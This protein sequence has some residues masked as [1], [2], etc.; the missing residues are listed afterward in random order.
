MLTSCLYTMYKV[1]MHVVQCH[2][3][4]S[5]N[6]FLH[7]QFHFVASTYMQVARFILVLTLVLAVD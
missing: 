2:K 3:M 1:T 4:C 5:T 6:I 7:M